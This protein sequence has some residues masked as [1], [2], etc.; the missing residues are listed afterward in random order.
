[1]SSGTITVKYDINGTVGR[2]VLVAA[3]ISAI[4]AFSNKVNIVMHGEAEEGMTT[5]LINITLEEA[6][7]ALVDALGG[8]HV[9]LGGTSL[10]SM[11]ESID[12][13]G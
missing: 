10:E 1:M 8:K 5:T 4:Y 9:Y 13:A 7:Q 2:A 11:R 3:N 6:R 12:V